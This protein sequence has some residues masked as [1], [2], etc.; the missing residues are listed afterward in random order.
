MT[1]RYRHVP[2]LDGLRG[3]SILL[4]MG[5]HKMGPVSFF[6]G[7]SGWVGVDV[8]FVVSGFLITSLLLQE[9]ADTG[10][11]NLR[12][13][14]ARRVCR[15]WPALYAFLIF[16]F[17]TGASWSALAVAGF[18]LTDLDLGFCWGHV[19]PSS[20]MSQLW[21]LAIEERFYLVWPV[22]L[23]LWGS[24]TAPLAMLCTGGVWV[25]RHWLFFNG[26]CC[27]RLTLSFDCR[28]DGIFLGCLAALAWCDPRGQKRVRSLLGGR[29]TPTVL[30]AFAVVCAACFGPWHRLWLPD[31]W[32]VY[33]LLMPAFEVAVTLFVLSLM[34]QPDSLPGRLLTCRWLCAIGVLSYSLYLWHGTIFFATAP[35]FGEAGPGLFGS[36]R[37]VLMEVINL[38]GSLLIAWMSYRFIETPFLGL[39]RRFEV[40]GDARPCGAVHHSLPA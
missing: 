15:L 22:A 39:K 14:Y 4:V 8:F 38:G 31:A 29:S 9:R 7:F 36:P 25:W 28:A 17:L 1:G 16:A 18:H 23:A 5:F 6:F 21:T 19:M 13:F 2:F 3:V 32:I 10:K 20:E 30:A 33:S 11:I 35:L 37:S 40:R 26:A 27:S 24:R 12:R 34:V